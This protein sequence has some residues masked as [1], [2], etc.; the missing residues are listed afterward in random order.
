MAT[1]QLIRGAAGRRDGP[2]PASEEERAGDVPSGRPCGCPG[3]RPR[4]GRRRSTFIDLFAGI[5]G[6]RIGLQRAGGRCVFTSEWDRYSQRTYQAWF[7]DPP[8]GDIT[9]IDPARIPD[10]D[11][12]AAGFPCQPFS[13]AGVSKKNSLGR[14]NG[15]RCA[16]QGT[17]FYNIAAVVEAKRPRAV[18]LENVKNLL[19]HDGGRTWGVVLSTLTELRYS[20]FHRIID[21][22]DYVPQHREARVRGG[23][24]S[25]R[26]RGRRSSSR[27]GRRGRGRSSAIFWRR[28][29]RE[30]HVERRAV[31]LPAAVRQEAPGEG[32]R[33][34]VRAGRRG[35][36]EPD[37]RRPVSQGRVGDSGAAAGPQPPPAD[38]PRVREADGVRRRP[39]DRRERHAGVPAVRELPGPGH[40]R[41]GGA[42][43][44]QSSE[45]DEEG[46]RIAGEKW[47]D[48]GVGKPT[49]PRRTCEEGRGAGPTARPC[50]SPPSPSSPN[51]PPW[52]ESGP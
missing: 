6:F 32:E 51:R 41:G 48:S 35:R 37:A 28:H 7:G 8:H 44:F 42:G 29:A 4:P 38:A 21:A 25:R 1:S 47:L 2:P 36:R 10:H 34:R 50:P 14:R 24:R 26:A 40:R 18:I 30:I 19:S 20:V 33:V 49:R 5:G 9:R 22:A 43:G 16:T 23:V 13:I 15:F 3:R 17:L 52:S 31:A 45:R 11:V 27:C 39:A 12:L 46:E